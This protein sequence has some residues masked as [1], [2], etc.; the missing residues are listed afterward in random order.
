MRQESVKEYHE[1]PRNAGL[2]STMGLQKVLVVKR[3]QD[4]C[5]AI[6]HSQAKAHCRFEQSFFRNLT[7]NCL[8]CFTRIWH[9]VVIC[10]Y[11]W[12]DKAVKGKPTATSI[13][14]WHI[15]EP[16]CSVAL[17][18]RYYNSGGHWA[19]FILNRRKTGMLMTVV[20]LPKRELIIEDKKV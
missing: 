16:P 19:L 5:Q 8:L 17:H 1:F 10:W 14:Q 13:L 20:V 4:S 7:M 3:W 15:L 12:N 2:N 18:G 9:Y 6:F 11:L